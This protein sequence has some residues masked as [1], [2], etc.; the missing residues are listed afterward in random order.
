MQKFRSVHFQPWGKGT[1]N[2]LFPPTYFQNSLSSRPSHTLPKEIISYSKI[3]RDQGA[4]SISLC[5]S[6]SWKLS[7]N[8]LWCKYMSYFFAFQ[9]SL[10]TRNNFTDLFG[11]KSHSKLYVYRIFLINQHCKLSYNY[12]LLQLR[13]ESSLSALLG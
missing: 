13:L 1:M 4:H 7:P 3:L 5:D 8:K 6:N 2:A 10:I 12:T 9:L 11:W